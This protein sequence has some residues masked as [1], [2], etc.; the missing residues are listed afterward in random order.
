MWKGS[1]GQQVDRDKFARI[2]EHCRVEQGITI[3]QA[4][5]SDA[6][7][8]SNILAS[9][10]EDPGLF[11]ESAKAVRCAID[12]F[13]VARSETGEVIGCA[14]LHRDSFAL[15]EVYAVAVTPKYQ[16]QGIGG[17]LMRSCELSGRTQGIRHLW[18]A[19]IKPAYF[20]RYGFEIISR[21]ELPG[22][23]LLRKLRQ[24]FR[25]PAGRWLPTLFGRHT[26]M[27]QRLEFGAGPGKNALQSSHELQ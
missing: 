2:E 25:Q 20:S 8:I 16:G 11:Q 1:S 24:T 22:S 4:R 15:G 7:A 23:V 6:G 5:I 10:R 9:N 27:R 3:E 26:L 21:W 13:V 12:D 14:G 18:L 17:Q 19:T